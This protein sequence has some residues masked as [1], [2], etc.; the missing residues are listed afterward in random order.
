MLSIDIDGEVMQ[1][2][3]D[4]AMYWPARWTLLIAD[5][6][7]GKAGVFR[8]RGIPLPAGVTEADLRR[9]TVLLGA[10]GAERLVILGD[11][12]HARPE[13]GEPWLQSFAAWRTGHASLAVQVVAGNHDRH[14][15]GP[16][17]DWGLDWFPEPLREGPFLF[18]HEPW[19]G[20]GVHV[21][22][23]HLHPVM[24]LRGGG[25]SLR[26]PVC[27]VRPGCTVLPAFGRF[28]GGHAITPGPGD[29]V[30]AMGERDVVD[31]G[32]SERGS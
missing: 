17:E 23:G 31:L 1:L 9:L 32:W 28:T 3:P 8:R 11:F 13:P 7:F 21:I 18:D 10:T 29:R 27:W 24:R 12:F 20:S 26:L 4:R 5:P 19:E 15:G 25:D 14:A 6:H 16:C 30:Y 22:G 2:C